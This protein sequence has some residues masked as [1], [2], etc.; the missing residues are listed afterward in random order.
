M[1]RAEVECGQESSQE[2]LE[3]SVHLVS[4]QSRVVVGG[5]QG[6][7]ALLLAV[8]VEAPHHVPH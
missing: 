7:K 6:L 3:I 1:V 4:P 2:G 5:M 8:S